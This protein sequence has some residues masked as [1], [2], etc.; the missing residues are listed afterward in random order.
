MSNHTHVVLHVDQ[1]M[2][3]SWSLEEVI[4]R[5]HGVFSGISLSHRYLQGDVLCEAEWDKLREVAEIWR[6]RL[7]S[8][9]WFMRC[10]NEHIA[11]LAN[12]EEGCTRRFWEGRFK[13]QVLLDEAALAACL[14]Y[15]DLNPVRAAMADTPEGSD[16]TSVQRRIRHLQ[17]AS[18]KAELDA[19][20]PKGLLPFVGNPRQAMPKDLPFVLS[21]YL[22]LV[23]WTGRALRDDKRGSI[24]AHVP[25]LLQR[26]RIVPKDWLQMTSRF[27]GQ[28]FHLVG[29]PAI[30]QQACIDLGQK[31]AWGSSH[32]KTLFSS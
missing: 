16:H 2:A 20:Q 5:W 30:V 21:D 24:P 11:R 10:L 26:L 31:W 17:D 6:G 23:D 25:P 19:A 9:S 22:E 3:E 18:D 12:A 4:E 28:F 7:M 13:S 14:A 27:E 29:R 32:C 15:V 1:A 8:I